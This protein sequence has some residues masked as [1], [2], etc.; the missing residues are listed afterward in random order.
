M[1]DF[2][3]TDIE[4][5]CIDD[6]EVEHP[7]PYAIYSDKPKFGWR[8]PKGFSQDSFIFEMRSVLPKS[9]SLTINGI[10][11]QQN[12]CTYWFS[13]QQKT[14]K[15][16]YRCETGASTINSNTGTVNNVSNLGIT[17]TWNGVCEVRLRL[18]DAN[19]NEL[20]THERTDEIYDFERTVVIDSHNVISALSPNPQ[21]R[22]WGSTNDRLYFCYDT[23]LNIHNGIESAHIRFNGGADM[24]AGDN[25]TETLQVSDSPLFNE[26]KNSNEL[27]QL[28]GIPFSSIL[29]IVA[30]F[31]K[32][33]SPTGIKNDG[34]HL[35][36]NKMYYCRAKSYDGFDYSDW[37]AVN[38]FMC[39]SGI[40]PKCF[41]NSV[42]VPC[43][44]DET[45]ELVPSYR[46][47]G[48]LVVNI[49]VEDGENDYVNAYLM[50]SMLVKESDVGELSENVRKLIAVNGST[51][52]PAYG[53][54]HQGKFINAMTKE[55]LLRIPTNTNID[56]TWCTTLGVAR[57]LTNGKMMN[58]VYLYLIAVNESGINS[59][60]E[61][62]PQPVMLDTRQSI[63]YNPE[64]TIGNSKM[65]ILNL[66]NNASGGGGISINNAMTSEAPQGAVNPER[67]MLHGE[68]R[69]MLKY[70][71]LPD[72]TQRTLIVNED[73][74][75]RSNN[76]NQTD[77]MPEED[78]R[79]QTGMVGYSDGR[80]TIRINESLSSSTTF[81]SLFD[82]INQTENIRDLNGIKRT[83]T[84]DGVFSVSTYRKYDKFYSSSSLVDGGWMGMFEIGV[85]EPVTLT[86]GSDYVIT[87]TYGDSSSSGFVMICPKCDTL[88]ILQTK[89]V[90][91]DNTAYDSL[92]DAFGEDGK[93]FDGTPYRVAFWCPNC[94]TVHGM[95]MKYQTHLAHG[96]YGSVLKDG[97]AYWHGYNSD[98]RIT[99]N[100]LMQRQ[101]ML[102]TERDFLRIV[103]EWK[104]QYRHEHGR[105]PNDDE[106]P[107][108]WTQITKGKDKNGNDMGSLVN[109]DAMRE[110]TDNG[111]G[112]EAYGL[113]P[114]DALLKLDPR[115]EF[116]SYIKML[117]PEA[118]S[119]HENI[120]ND[121]S[122]LNA[123]IELDYMY[124]FEPKEDDDGQNEN[125]SSD[126]GDPHMLHLAKQGPW[127]VQNRMM[128]QFFE[129]KKSLDDK[130]VKSG[131]PA[132]NGGDVSEDET[133]SDED[134]EESI[135]I[136]GE[137]GRNNGITE[138]RVLGTASRAIP[139][140]NS[141]GNATVGEREI[142][143][144]LIA[145][146]TFNDSQ[147]GIRSMMFNRMSCSGIIRFP[148][149]ITRGVNDMVRYRINDGDIVERSILDNFSSHDSSSPLESK[150][151]EFPYNNETVV[152]YDPWMGGTSEEER[153]NGICLY[154]RMLNE[155]MRDE[156]KV[157]IGA[158]FG[159]ALMID[160]SGN[161][162]I[163][164]LSISYKRK[165]DYVST[166]QMTSEAE[167][168]KVDVAEQKMAFS[169]YGN[170]AEGVD[171]IRNGRYMKFELLDCEN[172]CYEL[173]GIVPFTTTQSRR[174][175]FG[176]NISTSIYG[177]SI[178]S[179]VYNGAFPSNPSIDAKGDQSGEDAYA[180]DKIQKYY[181][182]GRTTTKH[183]FHAQESPIDNDL[184]S[185]E[186]CK[187]S[188]KD[189]NIVDAARYRKA[190]VG[191]TTGEPLFTCYK[192]EVDSRG[193]HFRFTE[194]DY[195]KTGKIYV[196]RYHVEDCNPFPYDGYGYRNWIVVPIQ[197][198]PGRY[199]KKKVFNSRGLAA[200]PKMI[201]VELSS[202][203]DPVEE[204]GWF[205][206][207]DEYAEPVSHERASSS[208]SSSTE[209]E[210]EP[211]VYKRKSDMSW[212]N[213]IL[214]KTCV[215]FDYVDISEALCKNPF[216]PAGQS[217]FSHVCPINFGGGIYNDIFVNR[218]GLYVM[219][220][221]D[222]TEQQKML[223]D[224]SM[225]YEQEFP[226]VD[227]TTSSSTTLIE[228]MPNNW[229]P[230]VLDAK[231]D[232]SKDEASS[233]EVIDLTTRRKYESSEQSLPNDF[234]YGKKSINSVERYKKAWQGWEN[235]IDAE[236]QSSG[237][238]L[239]QRTVEQFNPA[240]KGAFG[241]WEKWGYQP[242]N[243]FTQYWKDDKD[244]MYVGKYI[245]KS[246]KFVHG[247]YHDP[248]AGAKGDPYADMRLVGEIMMERYIVSDKTF[249]KV[250][251]NYDMLP[252]L[253]YR[254]IGRMTFDILPY[255]S[256]YPRNEHPLYA[257]RPE[258]PYPYDRQWRIGGWQVGGKD[259]NGNEIGR[260]AFEAQK[261]KERWS[262]VETSSAV[263]DLLPGAVIAYPET[264]HGNE[265]LYLQ[266]EWNNYNRIH[267]TMNVGSGSFLCL[268]AR[269]RNTDGT[270]AG[271]AFS[272]KTYTS[273]WNNDLMAWCIPY[274][275]SC[276]D[277][278]D[279]TETVDENGQS[280]FEDNVKYVF[281]MIPYSQ[282]P[283]GSYSQ[284]QQTGLSNQFSIS[285]TAQSPATIVSTTYDAWTKLLTINFRFDDALG[286]EY[287]I[288][289]F[290]YAPEDMIYEKNSNGGLTG[291][292]TYVSRD[293]FVV[294]GDGNGTGVLIGNLYNLASNVQTKISMPDELLITHSLQVSMS[295]LGI[296][297]ASG[298]RIMLDSDL[299]I[300]M[301]GFTLPVFTVK[302]WANEFLKPVEE[303]MM[304][305]LG[306]K[307]RWRKVDTY[308]EATGTISSEWEYLDE[309]N[310]VTVIGSI[311][312]TQNAI[313]EIS[314]KFEQ[315]H[316]G[317]NGFCDE[318]GENGD[319]DSFEA[320][321][322]STGKWNAFYYGYIFR[323]YLAFNAEKEYQQDFAEYEMS[324]GLNASNEFKAR[325]W[326]DY[327][328][329]ASNYGSW[330]SKRRL[331]LLMSYRSTLDSSTLL[332]FSAS[333][334][335]TSSL[336][337][338]RVEFIKDIASN[339]YRAYYDE[340]FGS[341]SESESSSGEE[342]NEELSITPEQAIVFIEESGHQKDFISYYSKKNRYA[343][344]RFLERALVMNQ[345]FGVV[346]PD[347]WEKDIIPPSKYQDAYANWLEDASNNASSLSPSDKYQ[348][349]L[350]YSLNSQL[351]L[352]R[353]IGDGEN[354]SVNDVPYS[355]TTL[356]S[357]E[358]DIKKA[359]ITNAG[360]SL[361]M[362]AFLQTPSGNGTTYSQKWQALNETLSQYKKTLQ[363]CQ[364]EKNM[365]ETDF[366]KNLI[367]QGFFCNGFVEN[368]PYGSE[369]DENGQ[370]TSTPFRWRVETRQY[371]G[372]MDASYDG[373]TNS[374]GSF[375][376]RYNM[377]YHFQMDFYDTFDSQE[378]G[379][380][381]ND[382]IFLLGG[383][384]D[385]D[386]ILAGI[387]D[388]D[389]SARTSPL[390]ESNNG[391]SSK[392]VASHD[393]LVVDRTESES[394]PQKGNSNQVDLRF[395]AT[396][397]IAKSELPQIQH[398]MVPPLAWRQAWK[399]KSQIEKET[400][401]PNEDAPETEREIK[402]IDFKST[403]YWR[404]APYNIVE[405]PVFETL[406]GG[407]HASN[408]Y[409]VIDCI[410]HSKEIDQCKTSMSSYDYAT[411]CFAS[412]RRH[413][414]GNEYSD[415]TY[416]SEQ[417]A[418]SIEC[419]AWKKNLD[420]IVFAPYMSTPILS[421]YANS[422]GHDGAVHK[423]WLNIEME[424]RGEVQFVTDR[425]RKV[426]YVDVDDEQ[427][428]GIDPSTI[429]SYRIV[430][431]LGGNFSEMLQGE[432]SL[433]EG[434]GYYQH[435]RGTS[436]HYLYQATMNGNSY[437]FIGTNPTDS[438][439]PS[440]AWL[441]YSSQQYPYLI[442]T[443]YSKN[444]VGSKVSMTAKSGDDDDS[445]TPNTRQRPEIRY[446]QDRLGC[447]DTTWLP[448]GTDREKPFVIRFKDHYLMFT[449][450][451]IGT[452][453]NGSSA[454][455][456]CMITM[457]RGFSSDVFG[458]ERQCFPKYTFE[459]IGDYVVDSVTVGQRIVKRKAVSLENPCVIPIGEGMY[460]MYFN[461]VFHDGEEYYT[462]IFKADTID[463]DEWNGI[464][465]VRMTD[466]GNELTGCLQP[467]VSVIPS[468]DNENDPL[469]EHPIMSYIMFITSTWHTQE[470]VAQGV[471]TSS[472]TIKEFR[473]VDGETFSQAREIY[474]SSDGGYSFCSPCLFVNGSDA[475]LYFSMESVPDQNGFV[476]SVIGS[477][478][479]TVD[480]SAG[481]E[482]R[483]ENYYGMSRIILE[484]A[485]DE[486]I[487]ND[488][489]DKA[490]NV[491]PALGRVFNG[492]F[493]I[494][495]HYSN[496]CVIWDY[497]NGCKVR[498]MYYNTYMHPYLWDDGTLKQF[499]EFMEKTICTDYFEEYYW[500]TSS[501][502]IYDFKCSID[503][504]GSWNEIQ[505]DYNDDY[506]RI[507][508]SPDG[509][510]KLRFPI[511]LLQDSPIID[512]ST[513]ACR[514]MMNLVP[515][516]H[517]I[518]CMA[519]GRWI[520]YDNVANTDALL[521]PET[522][523]EISY[524]LS[525]YSPMKWIAENNLVDAYNAWLSSQDSSATAGNEMALQWIVY[526]RNYPRYLW[527][528]RKGPGIYRYV[529]YDVMQN[530]KWNGSSLDSSSGDSSTE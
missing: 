91:A 77:I 370:K 137:D 81:H 312:E 356:I 373:T 393:D 307:S 204:I 186:G 84:K 313:S 66:E 508:A 318:I 121:G 114:D 127:W 140:W 26:G 280:K 179:V 183:K 214:P 144:K 328:N 372:K 456:A 332:V 460:R 350:T 511:S 86:G 277:M 6:N 290:R 486:F 257:T 213:R 520:G 187:I 98:S 53:E 358:S 7:L 403:Y 528:S 266:N 424:K 205:P 422:N 353:V 335:R 284:G 258:P 490:K 374:F 177:N 317:L 197:G 462:K 249:R 426:E 152:P 13:G 497:F 289:G 32:K 267:W 457:S 242:K 145:F 243:T 90:L 36:Y 200:V 450:K 207:E 467:N 193:Y 444:G 123:S 73:L 376:Q 136:E 208:S 454:Y 330:Y 338:E 12:T 202:G 417:S 440:G 352:D 239:S 221:Y 18:F 365:L 294:P 70:P 414:V 292:V 480:S 222:L 400:D 391:G 3:Q 379:T 432:Y 76:D 514:I 233:F 176:S 327:R 470:S 297:S 153:E 253:D 132:V 212:R 412:S 8:T 390:E 315:W 188:D 151:I 100:G 111:Y 22:K 37:C 228:T 443:L 502:P 108:K 215:V 383:N 75:D 125:G 120:Y 334:K 246:S 44:P 211:P 476:A 331:F 109:D 276:S 439:S 351:K 28:D 496:P 149:V 96:V 510:A 494:N 452:V 185:F 46:N 68:L 118:K 463:F 369:Y 83:T 305:L 314:D 321:L 49:R 216:T 475:T 409:A 78:N 285:K 39:T 477:I 269:A 184:E 438:E 326:L 74:G 130:G 320:W 64:L 41:I 415:D 431:V 235:R 159:N 394:I 89:I 20:C 11:S 359:T 17:E 368:Q 169:V 106:C 323:T 275:E 229:R 329:L 501:V 451:R 206:S 63:G 19:G 410:F 234:D 366:R 57:P 1:S 402:N 265:F 311:Q 195:R 428:T 468:Y 237:Y 31:E 401:K 271:N 420:S 435:T 95:D 102:T 360:R 87:E 2:H 349:F 340:H 346:T 254:L 230:N 278:I 324:L 71:V 388:A 377:Y 525:K 128:Y 282:N 364:N 530:Y 59:R 181:Y 42:G 295:S 381:I 264:L 189:G 367:K 348:S 399:D 491:F 162:P 524:S 201:Q 226:Y 172:S 483:T 252:F 223:S 236:K 504:G 283:D 112:K 161:D 378:G 72:T 519:E 191:E 94:K 279:M 523:N 355:T 499:D 5:Y 397:G 375:D 474:V 62:Y 396:F 299:S 104:E 65:K 363:L 380:P 418:G 107:Y 134:N 43:E 93:G 343:D 445:L 238:E 484:K 425:P 180:N 354:Y 453:V 119:F 473:G 97:Y 54:E 244:G 163:L 224:D 347:V 298:L 99:D 232:A 101:L 405:R 336:S 79:K 24:D 481:I 138:Y 21:Y 527:W 88:H 260:S 105:Y 58:N 296:K 357:T 515:K 261:E 196:R 160:E 45:G 33:N 29:D 150:R 385:K 382:T 251:E 255:F 225:P 156:V 395:S 133:E 446:I 129:G 227:E 316:I 361:A 55:S 34:I 362:S 171:G 387:D 408:G 447:F 513:G 464:S 219:G 300:N 487:I 166:I 268:Y 461:A 52:L 61:W 281:Y 250:D 301:V 488:T 433:V 478:K 437:W 218:Y 482:W 14:S 80:A 507:Y 270:W 240:F 248:V 124:D 427:E 47:N 115:P 165:L 38:A 485:D 411:V 16:E 155:S 465:V 448:H 287:D 167:A 389:N 495:S 304:S 526:T 421:Q 194:E 69:W 434:T 469:H 291:N 344:T 147:I 293:N 27:Y 15:T 325:K 489:S 103:E 199:H 386:R 170:I 146:S 288:T 122:K 505:S 259:M 113:F 117:P 416:E 471:G 241:I 442:D 217:P 310:A 455:K 306:Y 342:E 67:F 345:M 175:V 309:K 333:I 492:M 423:Q 56:I 135:P 430:G 231:F 190:M 419:P 506:Q 500:R 341:P 48:E 256:G 50:F 168:E 479:G 247:I 518:R 441:Y 60:M 178:P 182:T 126:S 274:D 143:N 148:I 493:S 303:R 40:P 203:A 173:A 521:M 110:Y 529:G 404:V 82:L 406:L 466:N 459:S 4:I 141:D 157:F 198:K 131:Y 209:S 174:H 308:D 262:G 522:N 322:K 319:I 192:D 273:E 472:M 85:G 154:T 142:A 245:P 35:H 458:E 339:E 272:V 10:V 286:R 512:Q 384:E 498:R 503:N 116:D 449:H 398:G 23:D 164:P 302:M 407:T 517:S 371:D 429:V 263:P 158:I 337:M 51:V 210:D 392:Y 139:Y 9:Y 516:A 509:N 30:F 220:A 413:L 92:S 436:S 25:V